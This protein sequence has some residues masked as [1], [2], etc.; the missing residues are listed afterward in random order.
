MT[1]TDMQSTH[2]DSTNGLILLSSLDEE[3]G[4]P[5]VRVYR[6]IP[7]SVQAGSLQQLGS[8]TQSAQ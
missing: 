6:D 7:T 4:G 8:D 5:L 1:N 2:T 3:D